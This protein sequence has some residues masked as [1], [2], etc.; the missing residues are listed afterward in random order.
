MIKLLRS[1]FG[2]YVNCAKLVKDKWIEV[3]GEEIVF[4]PVDTQKIN[5]NSDVTEDLFIREPPLKD[6]IVLYGLYTPPQRCLNRGTFGLDTPDEIVIK[7]P[8]D[9]TV[10][11][12]GKFPIG[13][14]IHTTDGR[15]WKLVNYYREC[16]KYL[17]E[18]CLVLVGEQ[19]AETV[20][21]G[22]KKEAVEV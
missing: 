1:A 12:V 9:S 2:A 18:T 14:L 4:Y 6:P 21:T 3:A 16:E 5:I 10:E 7:L 13:S 19:Y 8:F 22:P 20:T 11:K 17:G 15:K